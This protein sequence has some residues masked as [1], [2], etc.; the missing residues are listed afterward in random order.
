MDLG[1][2]R[3][4]E[5]RG[6]L[7]VFHSRGE[8]EAGIISKA[9]ASF[10]PVHSLLTGQPYGGSNQGHSMPAHGKACRYWTS[11]RQQASQGHITLSSVTPDDD[12][13]ERLGTSEHLTA[14]VGKETARSRHSRTTS[15]VLPG[16]A[17][18]KAV[19]F[20]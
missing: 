19:L 1:V 3:Q 18:S 14:Q 11:K 7:P 8:D 6:S 13:I 4:G 17:P 15:I 5:L 16:L 10:P 2:G 9:R 12:L 20:T